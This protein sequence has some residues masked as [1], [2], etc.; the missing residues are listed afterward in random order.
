MSHIYGL[1]IRGHGSFSFLEVDDSGKTE[2]NK[3]K[4]PE[5]NID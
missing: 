5:G 3:D 4:A 1:E 2:C